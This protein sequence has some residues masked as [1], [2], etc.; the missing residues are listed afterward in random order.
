MDEQKK[1][2]LPLGR[3]PPG[4]LVG[5]G[6]R[7]V[8]PFSQS[9]KEIEVHQN[10]PGLSKTLSTSSSYF[11]LAE[12]YFLSLFFVSFLSAENGSGTSA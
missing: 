12:A 2:L 10:F 8:L 5:N 9:L 1:G 6:A 11:V 3:V 4:F 7:Q